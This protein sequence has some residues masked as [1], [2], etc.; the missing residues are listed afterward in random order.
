MLTAQQVVDEARSWE[1]V[2]FLHQG[3]SR[4]GIDCVGYF[5]VLLHHFGILPDDLRNNPSY[6]RVP[7]SSEFIDTIEK[8]CTK[9]ENP[10]PA[11]LVVIKWP[12][13]KFPSHAAIIEGKMERPNIIHAY[14]KVGRVVR[15]GYREPWVR[16]THGIYRLPGVTV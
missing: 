6:G 9:V 13:A 12:G 5:A 1:G 14:Q 10:E 2:P 8:Y 4:N 3:R 7:N 16:M 15:V 11:A